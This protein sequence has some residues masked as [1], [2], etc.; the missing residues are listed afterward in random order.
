MNVRTW[1]AENRRAIGTGC[2]PTAAQ[3]L[4][5]RA[6]LGREAERVVAWNA[7]QSSADIEHLDSGS[8]RLL[9][10]V[11]HSLTRLG[12]ASPLLTRLKGVHRQS[13]FANQLLFQRVA[14]VLEALE[15]AQVPALVLKGVALT[16]LWYRDEAVRP[17][18]DADVLVKHTDI[19]AARDIL[20]RLGW[21]PRLEAP[22]WPPRFCA[23]WPF[24]D[25]QARE[26]DLHWHVFPECLSDDADDDFWMAAV[27]LNV[28]GVAVAALSPADQLLHVLMHGLRWN[29]VPSIR[30]VADA[31]T[32]LDQV[33]TAFDWPRLV[34]Q[35]EVRSF[36]PIVEVGLRYLH[37]AFGASIPPA[38]LHRLQARPLGWN[39]R[40]ERWS[41]LHAGIAA[42]AG[43][44][45]FGYLRAIKRT[46]GR[47]GP[48][49][50][51]GYV[52]SYWAVDG[53]W[54][55]PIAIAGKVA[56][57]HQAAASR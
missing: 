45:W 19:V 31:L 16:A 40:F 57:R 32:I 10:L 51:L 43:C 29:P 13:W 6:A 18:A 21:R 24:A 17:M 47:P 23:S 44:L 54:R 41:R 39:E 52:R 36:V 1:R 26:L 33:G 34:A 42:G 53:G 56:R 15:Q 12:V 11:Y 37:E 14:G 27:P 3:T 35:A 38:V 48:A 9:P 50:F 30:W 7:W 55:L 8:F 25:V 5:L 4:L 28:R 2:W 22:E 49:G 20:R 46:G